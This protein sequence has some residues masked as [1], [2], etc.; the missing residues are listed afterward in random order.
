[1]E[2]RLNEVLNSPMHRWS[3]GKMSAGEIA[4]RKKASEEFKKRYAQ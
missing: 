4:A 3:Q 1:M 2:A